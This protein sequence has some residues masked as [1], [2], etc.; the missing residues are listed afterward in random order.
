MMDL[1]YRFTTASKGTLAKNTLPV[2]GTAGNVFFINKHPHHPYANRT[3]VL[4][5][6]KK[7]GIV[8]QYHS[9]YDL[10]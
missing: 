1:Q 6:T 4:I 10:P 2:V 3:Y 5:V 9:G 8:N 7:C